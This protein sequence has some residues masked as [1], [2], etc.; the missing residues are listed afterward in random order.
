VW[1]SVPLSPVLATTMTTLDDHLLAE[2]QQHSTSHLT[3]A[4]LRSGAGIGIGIT[5][6]QMPK[7][8]MPASVLASGKQAAQHASAGGPLRA[9]QGP[10]AATGVAAAGASQAVGPGIAPLLKD[11]KRHAKVCGYQ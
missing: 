8:L 9:A 6:A 11:T 1:R 10:G 3:P 4:Q 5:P 2:L 7:R